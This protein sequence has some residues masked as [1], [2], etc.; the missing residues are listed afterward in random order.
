[1]K[2]YR[3]TRTGQG[4]VTSRK[5]VGQGRPV[6]G[7]GGATSRK[8]VGQGGIVE[9]QRDSEAP[10]RGPCKA[11]GRTSS[12]TNGREKDVRCTRGP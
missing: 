5:G 3:R 11:I 4:G 7:Q 10:D 6:E 1:M 2:L 12:T 8:G 9:R